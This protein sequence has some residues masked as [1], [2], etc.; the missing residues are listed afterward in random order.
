MCVSILRL[1]NIN[2][3]YLTPH[4]S[5]GGMSSWVHRTCT[6]TWKNKQ[7]FFALFFE[8][9]RQERGNVIALATFNSFL[10]PS[11]CHKLA[12]KQKKVL[13]EQI[14]KGSAKALNRSQLLKPLP[15][16]VTNSPNVQDF[17]LYE[18]DLE[19]CWWFFSVKPW[20]EV[21]FSGGWMGVNLLA[22]IQKVEVG[23]KTVKTALWF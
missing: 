10:R 18:G 4:V 22:E 3:C 15:L 2:W 17:A 6:L 11:M 23:W 21:A 8:M 14:G 1:F 16:C 5:S 20:D 7:L 13:L 19:T 12:S 9:Q